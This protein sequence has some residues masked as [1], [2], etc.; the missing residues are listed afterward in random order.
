MQIESIQPNKITREVVQL[1]ANV[2][3]LLARDKLFDED[4]FLPDG[5]TVCDFVTS[6]GY[7][8]IDEIERICG[9]SSAE[10]VTSFLTT[11]DYHQPPWSR[12][13]EVAQG[14]VVQDP[15]Y[16]GQRPEVRRGPGRYSED[17]PW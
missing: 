10:R 12:K 13:T 11:I 17:I 4:C 15:I 16:K 1:R 7:V 8:L 2:T 14:K 6:E 9:E 3:E 5:L